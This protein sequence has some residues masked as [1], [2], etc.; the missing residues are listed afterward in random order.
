[1]WT[2]PLVALSLGFFM[3]VMDATIVNVAL[4]A[5]AYHLNASISG[6]QW[7][8][9][10]YALMFS[11]ALL[12]SGYLGDRYGAK[13]L[14]L[15]GVWGFMITSLLCALSTTIWFLIVARFLQ[16]ICAAQMMPNALTLI[17]RI[18]QNPKAHA[19]ALGV[20]GTVGG[21]G[22]AAGP[23]L[24][25]GLITLLSW[26]AVF[27]I[28]VIFGSICAGLSL[29]SVPDATR[30]ADPKPFDWVGH[31][32]SIT[33]ICALAFGIIGTGAAYA[34][35]GIVAAFIIFCVSSVGFIAVQKRICHP[36]LPLQLF[37]SRHFSAAMIIG[38][39]INLGFYGQLFLLPLYFYKVSDY[40]ILE[41]GFALF[42]Q[43]CTIAFFAYL[44][45]KWI[46]NWGPRWVILFGL[47]VGIVGFLS[48]ASMISLSRGYAYLVI[49]LMLI[50][51]SMAAI[52]P[53]TTI[54][55]ARSVLLKSIQGTASGAFN[56]SRQIGTLVGVALLGSVL[57]CTDNFKDGM[58][59][60]LLV[61]AIDFLLAFY[62]AYVIIGGR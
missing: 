5:I 44:A 27:G 58:Q 15:Q 32:L 13:R 36:M 21:I 47:G 22:A 28:N 17:A 19:R 23:L 35:S 40:S 46:S 29:K 24:G 59:I 14:F 49:P 30:R 42:P 8:V 39:L 4:P 3:V 16:G 34:F 25:A 61:A 50:G 38:F 37:K 62:V 54:V 55:M 6:L 60:A 9:D 45:G 31:I 20:W 41:T 11:A 52:M 10:G 48:L 26:R 43:M 53:A 51:L 1:M 7:V 12:A 57:M 18:F 33:A 2:T 56:S